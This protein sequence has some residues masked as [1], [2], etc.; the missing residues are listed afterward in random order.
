MAEASEIIRESFHKLEGLI[1]TFDFTR[2]GQGESMD[3]D[4][5]GI[6]AEGILDRTV[7]DQAGVDGIFIANDPKYTARKRKLYNVELIG[8]RTGQMISLPSLLGNVDVAPDTVLITYGTGQP[9]SS[10]M[11]SNYISTSDKAVTDTAKAGYF[12]AKKGRWFAIDD[13]I[14][15]K[16]REYFSDQLGVF[17]REL[18][19]R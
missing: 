6:V 8:F 16:V 5:A 12:T 10:S 2:Q 9:P 14:S 1:A 17:I 15:D 11:S 13:P 7:N 4:A 18:N 3:K 19:A